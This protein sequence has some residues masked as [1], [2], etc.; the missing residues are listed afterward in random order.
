[1]GKENEKSE[2]DPKL[3]WFI[4][5]SIVCILVLAQNY[6]VALTMIHIFALSQ[7]PKPT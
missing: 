7:L 1:M 4:I 6:S 2:R 3:I 5:N